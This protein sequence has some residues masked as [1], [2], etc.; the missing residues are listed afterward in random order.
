VSRMDRRHFL[1]WSGVGAVGW[2][3]TV[4]LLGYFL[5]KSFPA[6]KDHLELA[7]LGIVVLSLVPMVVEIVRARRSGSAAEVL[8]DEHSEHRQHPEEISDGRA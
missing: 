7:I 5:G 4:T 1:V 2:V 3:W 8:T 6:L